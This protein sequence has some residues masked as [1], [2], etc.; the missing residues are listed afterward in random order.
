MAL[1]SLVLFDLDDTLVD[2]RYATHKGLAAL[3]EH[4]TPFSRFP[5]PEIETRAA[6]ILEETHQRVLKGL[7]SPDAGRQERFKLLLASY[8]L[9][10]DESTIAELTKFY[11]Q[12]YR[13]HRRPVPGAIDLLT[14]LRKV[15]AIGI[16]T[17]NFLKEQRDKLVYCGIDS[18]VDFMVTSEEAGFAKPEREIFLNALSLHGS[19]PETTVMIGDSW[20]I[21]VLGAIAAGIRPIWF[22]RSTNETS[23]RGHVQEL[24]TFENTD[25]A[26]SLILGP[27]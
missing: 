11:R 16:I 19:E 15:V 24:H 25:Q 3:K 4:F 1:P 10:E 22:N 2:H 23:W 5:L 8:Q 17:N 27:E 9:N 18:L 6:K 14:E 26:L 20:E 12:T 13:S 7:L 21:D